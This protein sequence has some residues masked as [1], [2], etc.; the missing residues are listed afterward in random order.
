VLPRPGFLWRDARL[1]PRLGTVEVRIKDAQSRVHD[2]APL[3]AVVHCLVRRHADAEHPRATPPEVI[4]EN[5]FLAARDGMRAQ[6]IDDRTQH[7]GYARQRVHAARDG[8]AAL[9]ARLEDEFV[10]AGRAVVA[11]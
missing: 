10:S 8:L 11:A 7:P 3:A 9:P 5:R 4:A 6:L 2:A 1:Q